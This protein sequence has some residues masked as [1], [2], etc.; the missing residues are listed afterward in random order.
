MGL[1][2]FFGGSL[3]IHGSQ[4]DV[5]MLADEMTRQNV[6]FGA[7][8]RE[9]KELSMRAPYSRRG[10]VDILIKKLGIAP[11]IEV[12]G[13][14][15]LLSLYKKRVGLFVGAALVL[16]LILLS[17]MFILTLE[18]VG[19]ERLSEEFVISLMEAEGLKAGT[20]KKSHDLAMIALKAELE[21]DD[22]AWLAVNIN[23]TKAVVELR[24]TKKKPDVYDNSTPT[25]MIAKCDGQIIYTE[26]VSGSVCVKRYDVVK[27]GELLI[28]GIVDSKAYGYKLVRSR[29]RVL[30][31]TYRS[32][33]VS[34]A[35]DKSVKSYT[36]KERSARELRLF[37]KSV[38][39]GKD[40]E[41]FENFD[42]TETKEDLSFFGSV[43]LPVTLCKRVYREY[44][45]KTKRL[46]EDEAKREALA[47][48][49]D[50]I[51]DEIAGEITQR[52]DV[53]RMT[54]SELI[55]TSELYCI[56][57]ICS[58]IPIDNAWGYVVE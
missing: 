24:E 22:I 37:G 36:G 57:D 8:L 31:S 10:D 15:R 30:A 1:V 38:F 32:F 5:L 26:A 2:S 7:L 53:F 55:L 56:E 54:E 25:N 33:T 48:M 47:E 19:N 18:V 27:E 13:M 16:A 28:S 41:G 52:S 34:V 50:I 39:K 3:K 21:C 11:D 6:P 29:G 40:Y 12:C 23:G 51:A 45:P 43:S 17:D 35:L 49:S 14:P 9:D 44:V 42:V 20:L 58:E 4:R 46:S